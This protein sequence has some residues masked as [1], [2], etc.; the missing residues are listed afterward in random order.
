MK[1]PGALAGATGVDSTNETGSFQR[2]D[3]P[4]TP[5]KAIS[6]F[7]RSG[8]KAVSRVLYYALTLADFES[9]AALRTIMVVRLSAAERAALAYAA[10]SS[11]DDD[12]GYR[13]ASL[14]LFGTG[15][16]DG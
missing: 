3:T 8:H 5:R 16:H 11:L 6:K 12:Q 2:Q 10:L 7:G 14:V 4:E 15:A 1:N 13:V 9:W